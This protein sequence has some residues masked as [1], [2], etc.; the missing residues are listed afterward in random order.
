MDET[1]ISCVFCSIKQANGRR[2]E[3]KKKLAATT[4]IRV[5]LA[6]ATHTMA[7]HM[8]IGTIG[9]DKGSKPSEY[10]HSESKQ[11]ETVATGTS[12][13]TATLAPSTSPAAQ[14]LGFPRQ[15]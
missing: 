7:S 14:E 9:V 15:C 13:T 12:A 1:F 2:G 10:S 11:E 4:H 6:P 3:N 5:S 8:H